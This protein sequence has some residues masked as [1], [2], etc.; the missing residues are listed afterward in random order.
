MIHKHPNGWLEQ[1][2]NA[3]YPSP[4]LKLDLFLFILLKDKQTA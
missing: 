3:L 2:K 4:F 1:I